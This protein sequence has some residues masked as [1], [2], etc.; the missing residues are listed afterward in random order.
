MD[1]I[2]ETCA[3]RGSSLL[4][5]LRGTRGLCKPTLNYFWNCDQERGSL[6]RRGGADCRLRLRLEQNRGG[7]SRSKKGHVV[8]STQAG[9]AI[10]YEHDALRQS[11]L[12]KL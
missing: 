9:E 8:G 5:S 4:P 6:P 10:H 7:K 1:K 2:L 3:I 12:E 11:K